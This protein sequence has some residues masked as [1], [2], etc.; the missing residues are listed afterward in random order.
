MMN[1]HWL[2]RLLINYHLLA[3]LMSTLGRNALS[4]DRDFERIRNSLLYV[5]S[6]Y[7]LTIMT[8]KYLH[9]VGKNDAEG[10][11]LADDL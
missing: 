4:C 8:K 7:D 2:A 6:T 10:Q 9:V 11:Q 5:Y 3:N 1:E